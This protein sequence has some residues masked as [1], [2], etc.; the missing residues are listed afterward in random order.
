MVH[1]L[2][3]VQVLFTIYQLVYGI[4]ET[5]TL[6]LLSH[7]LLLLDYIM[8]FFE[9]LSLIFD[10]LLILAIFLKDHLFLLFHDFLFLLDD[11]LNS[12]FNTCLHLLD[13][14][15][16]ADLTL[17]QNIFKTLILI[18][19]LFNPELIFHVLL[20]QVVYFI[21]PLLGHDLPLGHFFDQLLV[22]VL[23]VSNTF[24][25]IN[26]F[27]FHDGVLYSHFVVFVPF[28]HEGFQEDVDF[29]YVVQF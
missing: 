18:I 1:E 5:V 15:S 12:C 19:K 21:L 11:F 26:I 13:L 9:L 25:F 14:I 4:L 10:F 7:L 3:L 23:D 27:S 22:L 8:G 2:E 17:L 24:H 6:F 20:F 28:D 29:V 16:L